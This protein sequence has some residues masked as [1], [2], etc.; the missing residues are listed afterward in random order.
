MSNRK[1]IKAPEWFIKNL[2]EE[3]VVEGKMLKDLG[4]TMSETF[5]NTVKQ[6]EMLSRITGGNVDKELLYTKCI[7]LANKL[8]AEGRRPPLEDILRGSIVLK[9]VHAMSDYRWA[10]FRYENIDNEFGKANE[11]YFCRDSKFIYIK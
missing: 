5:N 4:L 3:G 11:L 7:E 9:Y 10:K 2:K 1:K 6:F 8:T